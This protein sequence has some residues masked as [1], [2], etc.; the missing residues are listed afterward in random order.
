MNPPPVSASGKRKRFWKSLVFWSGV[1]GLFFLI[2]GW[3]G[4][5]HDDPQLN[6]VKEGNRW[7]IGG[8]D[9]SYWFEQSSFPV[10]YQRYRDGFSFLPRENRWEGTGVV[11]GKAFVPFSDGNGEFRWKGI[12]IGCWAAVILY[13]GV[14]TLIVILWQRRGSRRGGGKKVSEH[15]LPL[16]EKE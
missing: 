9:G 15:D 11:F 4:F 12:Y 5:I 3:L 7:A 16:S 6:W 1:P 2:W 14:W 10:H 8:G 13:L